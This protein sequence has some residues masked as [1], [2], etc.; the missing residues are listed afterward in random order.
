M[1]RKSMLFLY[2]ALGSLPTDMLACTTIGFAGSYLADGGTLI[3]KNRDAPIKGYQ[4]LALFK[5]EG[6]HRYIALTYGSDQSA[7]E[8]PYVASG[9]NEKG[10]TVLVNDPASHYPK[11]RSENAIETAIVRKILES[12]ASVADVRKDARQLFGHNNPALYIVA[13]ATRVANFEAGYEGKYSERV[14]SNG[15][16]W[17]L[18]EYH[19]P[20]TEADNRVITQDVK[21]RYETL[22]QW[23]AEHTG[24]VRT[25]DAF[26]LLASTYH[27]AFNSIS[28]EITVAQYAVV[29]SNGQPPQLRVKLTIPTQPYNQYSIPLTSEFFKETAAGPLDNSVYGLLGSINMQ[30]FEQFIEDIEHEKPTS[31]NKF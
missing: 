26:R 21:S 24:D 28:R 8:Y 3:A 4:R 22:K 12:Y 16:V 19:L 6:K 23:L 30:K 11:G 27:G 14:E 15:Y 10:L 20:L 5:P 9:T 18:N 25:G 17:A 31:E 29:T 13:D 2:F 7:D 1:Q